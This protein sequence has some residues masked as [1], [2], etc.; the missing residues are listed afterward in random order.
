[1]PRVGVEE[2]FN[3]VF[4]F[5][6]TIYI[7]V[8]VQMTYFHI[9]EVAI[10]VQPAMAEGANY[11]GMSTVGAEFLYDSD[12]IL[13]FLVDLSLSGSNDKWANNFSSKCL[14]SIYADT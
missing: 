11:V 5:Q 1:M 8:Q 6:T 14:V 7:I 10:F 3:T 12:F 9:E 13:N 2:F 4:P